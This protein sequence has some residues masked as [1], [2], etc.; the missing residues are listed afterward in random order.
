MFWGKNNE[1]DKWQVSAMRDNI[2]TLQ[3]GII[4][5]TIETERERDSEREKE[6]ERESVCTI[7]AGPCIRLAFVWI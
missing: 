3:L 6:G 2:V 1:R 4:Q 5:T 7:S